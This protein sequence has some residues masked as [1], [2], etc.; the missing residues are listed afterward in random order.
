MLRNC[1]DSVLAVSRQGRPHEFSRDGTEAGPAHRAQALTCQCRPLPPTLLARS[2]PL[3]LGICQEDGLVLLAVW[4]VQDQGLHLTKEFLQVRDHVGITVE[5]TMAVRPRTGE[6]ADAQP[7]LEAPSVGAGI[8]ATLTCVQLHLKLPAN[9]SSGDILAGSQGRALGE[10]AVIYD[11]RQTSTT[12]RGSR[13]SA[14]TWQRLP[15]G[16]RCLSVPGAPVGE[17]AHHTTLASLR[18]VGAQRSKRHRPEPSWE[19]AGNPCVEL[20][21]SRASQAPGVNSP[22]SLEP[23][24][25][26]G[27]QLPGTAAIVLSDSQ[28]YPSP[29]YLEEAEDGQIYRLGR[30]NVERQVSLL[31]H[32]GFCLRYEAPVL[33]RLPWG[34]S[35]PGYHWA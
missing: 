28:V 4:E 2:E 18:Y 12:P 34:P 21:G 13:S 3:Y 14:S 24:G 27:R 32:L 26:L 31:L 15:P 22:P 1:G 23:E 10:A 5:P 9:G 6:G 16:H 17:H 19:R 33:I 20:A 11:V 29:A 7:T 25:S 8:V 30:K 35:G